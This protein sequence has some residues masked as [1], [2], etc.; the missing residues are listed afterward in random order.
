MCDAHVNIYVYVCNG[1]FVYAYAYVCDI[2]HISGYAYVYG[3][4]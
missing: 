1:V 2:V 4:V 3:Y